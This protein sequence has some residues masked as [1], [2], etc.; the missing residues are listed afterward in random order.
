MGCKN[1]KTK[2]NVDEGEGGN[3][4]KVLTSADAEAASGSMEASSEGLVSQVA[5]A[6]LDAQHRSSL[7]SA[8][9]PHIK[10]H[11]GQTVSDLYD[12]GGE[13]VKLGE[14]MTGAVVRAKDR[15]TGQFV[16]LKNVKKHLVNDVTALLKEIALLAQLDHPNIVRLIGS[17]EDSH[18]VYMAL[19]LCSGGAL[20]DVLMKSQSHHFSEEYVGRMMVMACRAVDFC[21]KQGI[22]HR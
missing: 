12:F 2:N 9:I 21:H 4:G 8:L 16:A 15:S 17:C 7:K 22:A 11:K 20:L 19:E 5:R 14:G 3:G 18:N 10:L 13:T 6:K 1:T